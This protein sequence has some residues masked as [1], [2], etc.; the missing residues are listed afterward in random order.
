MKWMLSCHEATQLISESLDRKLPWSY[1]LALRLHLA[2]CAHCARAARQLHLLRRLFRA[3]KA[4]EDTLDLPGLS[5]EK[6][7][8]LKKLLTENDP[9]GK[10]K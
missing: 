3:G 5:A 6:K 4:S 8:R 10:A 7:K 9:S 1:R 2:I